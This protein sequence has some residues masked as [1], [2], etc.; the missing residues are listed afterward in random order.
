[1]E[2]VINESIAHITCACGQ[3]FQVLNEDSTNWD[4]EATSKM[5]QEH[6]K[7]EEE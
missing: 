3:K 7:N 4:E 6:L 2:N 1:M 5:Y